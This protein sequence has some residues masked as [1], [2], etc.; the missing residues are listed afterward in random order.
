MSLGELPKNHELHIK[1][2]SEEFRTTSAVYEARESTNHH[3]SSYFFLPSLSFDFLPPNETLKL[4]KQRISWRIN[5]EV[6]K[7]G[8][9]SMSRKT[10]GRI[11]GASHRSRKRFV[12]FSYFSRQMLSPSG[13]VASLSD[14][15]NE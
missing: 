3:N 10:A 4:I 2:D 15:V 11:S 8:K 12:T 7:S 13:F 6:D 14:T 1:P 9:A 5:H